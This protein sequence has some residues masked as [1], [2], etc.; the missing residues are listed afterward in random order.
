[1]LTHCR[2][3]W[4]FTKKHSIISL[5]YENQPGDSGEEGGGGSGSCLTAVAEK[6]PAAKSFKRPS[7]SSSPIDSKDT[8]LN[9][10]T[11][12]S[13]SSPLSSAAASFSL[14]VPFLSN[15]TSSSSPTSPSPGRYT[16]AQLAKSYA[17]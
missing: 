3:W 2:W 14:L 11:T 6:R 10:S 1:M 7:S 16:P 8:V 15:L 13:R 9:L 5:Y 17:T 12:Q 4:A